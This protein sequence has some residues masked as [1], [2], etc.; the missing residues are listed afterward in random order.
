[1]KFVLGQFQNDIIAII[2]NMEYMASVKEN[3]FVINN[4]KKQ[5]FFKI[6]VIDVNN[7]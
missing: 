7:Y 2:S 1:M 6:Y 5:L 4:C 3:M